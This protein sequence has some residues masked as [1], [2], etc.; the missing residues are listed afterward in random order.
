MFA[1]LGDQLRCI[2]METGVALTGREDSEAVEMMAMTV[3]ALGNLFGNDV[4]F[5]PRFT[6]R[7]LEGYAAKTA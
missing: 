2:R 5:S 6:Y 7:V 1:D 4:P 3:R